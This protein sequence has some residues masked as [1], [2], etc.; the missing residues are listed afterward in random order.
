[1]RPE[2]AVQN[3]IKAWRALYPEVQYV[4]VSELGLPN[5][6]KQLPSYLDSLF[7]TLDGQPAS[8]TTPSL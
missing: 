5:P 2:S 7:S 3:D 1:M 4:Y 6:W 8:A